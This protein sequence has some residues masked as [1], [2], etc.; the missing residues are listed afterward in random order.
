[1]KYI[2]I[3]ARHRDFSQWCPEGVSVDDCFAPLSAIARRVQEIKDELM[4]RKG[5]KVDYVV[6]TSDEPAEKWWQDVAALGWLRIDHSRTEELYGGWYVTPTLVIIKVLISES[7]GIRF[8]SMLL[9]SQ[10][11]SALWPMIFQQ[12]P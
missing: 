6:M 3:H 2:S 11:E 9:F 8:L 12:C 10:M 7:L 1:L 5:L 4:A